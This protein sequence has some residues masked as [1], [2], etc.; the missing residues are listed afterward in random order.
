M[1]ETIIKNFISL[2][3]EKYKR[4]L[5][6]IIEVLG[7]TYEER[8]KIESTFSD[9][10]ASEKVSPLFTFSESMISCFIHDILVKADF[11]EGKEI[12]ADFNEG[13]KTLFHYEKVKKNKNN[14]LILYKSIHR[15]VKL[16][17]KLSILILKEEKSW[18]RTK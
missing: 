12:T 11:D 17:K 18:K 16:C 14:I 10:R 9:L 7:G 15:Y 13:M 8:K 6:E 1:K 2:Y 3:G 4:N 5:K